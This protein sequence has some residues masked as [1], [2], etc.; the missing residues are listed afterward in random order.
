E[1]AESLL[2]SELFGYEKGAFTGANKTKKGM[3][4][5]AHGGILFLDEIATMSLSMQKKLLKAIEEKSFYPL[6]SEKLVHSEFRL[7][8]A[9]CEDLKRKI[10]SGDMRS[11]FFFRIEGFNVILKPLRERKDDLNTL[12]TH[13][14]KK[15]ER[16]IVF[17]SGA[18]K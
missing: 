15:G 9:T 17:D 5:L 8:S 1:L 14:I 2:E 12:I 4:E 18:K 11:D 6:G 7:I 3:L 13:F 10:E 16:R